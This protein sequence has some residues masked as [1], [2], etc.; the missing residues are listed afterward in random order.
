MLGWK[1]RGAEEHQGMNLKSLEVKRSVL[2]DRSINGDE[3]EACWGEVTSGKVVCW[4]ALQ[5]L[6]DVW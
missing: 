3:Q 4:R 2:D 5:F 6:E 1:R